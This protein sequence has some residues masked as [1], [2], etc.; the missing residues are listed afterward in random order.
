MACRDCRTDFAKNARNR[1]VIQSKSLVKDV[2]GGSTVT[3]VEVGTYWAW[4]I[5]LSVREQVDSEQ[6]RSKATHKIIIRYQSA[7][8]NTK[9]TGSYRM[10]FDGRIYSIVGVKNFDNSLKSYGTEFQELRV[11][12]NGTVND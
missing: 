2:H 4:L 8:K 10:T 12:D 6:L 5:P 9:T 7:L 11:E 1:V 3:W